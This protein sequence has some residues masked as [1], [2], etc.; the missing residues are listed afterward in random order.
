MGLGSEGRSGYRTEESISRVGISLSRSVS[1][2]TPSHKR[3]FA[4]SFGD[5]SLVAVARGEQEYFDPSGIST[6]QEGAK[7][8]ALMRCCK[9]LG[10]ASELWQVFKHALGLLAETHLGLGIRILFE[11]SSRITVSRC[12]VSM[13]L[14]KKSMSIFI[15]YAWPGLR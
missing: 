3:P 11:S 12:S 10:I 4:E 5:Y 15:I 7:S 13:Q 8:N 14:R 2:S 6:A 1:R 9:D